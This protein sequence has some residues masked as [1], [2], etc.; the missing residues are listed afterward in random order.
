MSTRFIDFWSKASASEATNRS[1]FNDAFASMFGQ[2]PR[3]R[4]W[5]PADAITDAGVRVLL[6]VALYAFNDMY[7]LDRVGEYLDERCHTP[8]RLDVLNMDEIRS[9]AELRSCF[10][11]QPLRLMSPIA[12]VWIDGRLSETAFG[13]DTLPL[14]NRI[15]GPGR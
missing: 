5:H 7:L 10:A 14:V 2:D 9:D 1:D 8:L 4:L 12:G 3:F 13:T 15:I 6:A 11:G